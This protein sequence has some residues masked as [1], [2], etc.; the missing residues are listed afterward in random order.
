ME[1]FNDLS[2]K[3]VD[4]LN[5]TLINH[6]TNSINAIQQLVQENINQSLRKPKDVVL[7]RDY[8]FELKDRLTGLV[9]HGADGGNGQ[10]L[11]SNLS[12][13][14]AL[15]ST[16]KD[17]AKTSKKSIFVPGTIAPFVIDAP[18]AEMD[19]T[20]RLNTFEF[21]PS[22]S[23]QLILFLSTGQWDEQYEKIIGEF[24]GKRYILINHDMSN[25]FKKN[26]LIVNN[27]T[28]QL[29]VKSDNKEISA[30][31]IEEI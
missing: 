7:T 9:D 3:I 17:R 25:N 15:I 1:N 5:K 11:L 16:S 24:I 26:E 27:K 19:E 8:K 23:H 6:E 2:D 4:K 30:T 10:T 28:Y 20:Y 18:F 21:L 29:N 22:Q 31:T 12:F 14:S 13:I